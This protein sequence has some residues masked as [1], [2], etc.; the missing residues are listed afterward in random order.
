MQKNTKSPIKRPSTSDLLTV[1]E[2]SAVYKPLNITFRMDCIHDSLKCANLLR[3]L[4]SDD[5]AYREDFNVLLVNRH[6]KAL[7]LRRASS[8]G[9]TGTV[10]DV[11]QIMQ[12][13]ILGNATAIILAHNHP[14]GN[15]RP[16]QHDREITERICQAAKLFDIKVLDHIILTP[17]G[18][19]SFAD[20][21]DL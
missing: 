1:N 20:N 11:R 10:V 7:S 17:K 21:G 14:S 13:A 19:Y 6:N 8:G 3:K 15:L 9:I 12:F 16:S 18:Y 2:V 5:I 4:W